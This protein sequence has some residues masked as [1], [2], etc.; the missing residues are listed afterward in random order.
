M[1]SVLASNFSDNIAEDCGGGAA[2][3]H[4]NVSTHESRFIKL[5][6]LQIQAVEPYFQMN[7][8]LLISVELTSVVIVPQMIVV[9]LCMC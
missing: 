9:E 5:I 8:V 1:L 7:R 4:V 3:F 6:M 2:V